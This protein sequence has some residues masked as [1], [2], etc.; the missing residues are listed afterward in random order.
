MQVEEKI[1]S[2]IE[3]KNMIVI[4]LKN[5]VRIIGKL[6]GTIQILDIDMVKIED[7]DRI[8]SG[9][10]PLHTIEKISDIN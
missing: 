10:C 4:D 5:G 1:K 6:T 3:S 7:A 8:Q 2:A 9:F